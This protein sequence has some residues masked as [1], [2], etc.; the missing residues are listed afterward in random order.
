VIAELAKHYYSTGEMP[1]LYFWRDQ[2]GLEIDLIIEDAGKLTPVETKSWQTLVAGF[3]KGL[4]RWTALAGEAAGDPVL[5]YGGQAVQ[6]RSGI[7]V[8]GWQSM[9]SL[10]R[11]FL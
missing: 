11:Q 5:I 1:P 7:H 6:Q 4:N 10:L 9:D 3:F 8:Y 2:S